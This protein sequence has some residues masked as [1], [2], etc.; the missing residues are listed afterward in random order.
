M[1]EE[2]L[3]KEITFDKKATKILNQIPALHRQSMVNLGLHMIAK[4]KYFK[5]LAGL[6]EFDDSEDV[7]NLDNIET[8]QKKEQESITKVAEVKTVK[9]KSSW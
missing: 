2:I 6:L 1:E 9:K 4:T 5:E 7:I 3:R 8:I